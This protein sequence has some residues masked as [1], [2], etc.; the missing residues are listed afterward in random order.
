MQ[1][2]YSSNHSD[3]IG[4]YGTYGISRLANGLEAKSSIVARIEM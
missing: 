2:W 1:S 3:D 4:K